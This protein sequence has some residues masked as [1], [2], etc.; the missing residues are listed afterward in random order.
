MFDNQK[1]DGTIYSG[2]DKLG[3]L[4]ISTIATAPTGNPG[5]VATILMTLDTHEIWYY[6]GFIASI[7]TWK[8]LLTEADLPD[9]LTVTYEDA[10]IGDSGSA[11]IVDGTLNIVF[12]SPSVTPIPASE[13]FP[14]YPRA[15]YPPNEGE[16][17][18]WFL[19]CPADGTIQI[20]CFVGGMNIYIT[21]CQGQWTDEEFWPMFNSSGECATEPPPIF[22][23]MYCADGSSYDPVTCESAGGS[24]RDCTFIE[25]ESYMALQLSSYNE[26]ATAWVWFG[27]AYNASIENIGSVFT[28]AFFFANATKLIGNI[29]EVIFKCTVANGFNPFETLIECGESDFATGLN[30]WHLKGAGE[31]P[32]VPSG[33]DCVAAGSWGGDK[34]VPTEKTIIIIGYIGSM[35]AIPTVTIDYTVTA[36]GQQLY[37]VFWRHYPTGWNGG[38]YQYIDSS[39]GNHTHTNSSDFGTY[40]AVVVQI[41]PAGP[42][43]SPP[44]YYLNKVTLNCS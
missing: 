21:E 19:K 33:E 38:G 32:C 42:E 34:F 44:A 9:E 11:T 18:T 23:L 3:K 14:Y 28:R 15:E 13:K 35:T 4:F 39:L 16:F 17:K 22:P 40:D 25:G 43:Y 41:G 7:H 24:P 29:G 8:R 2:F 5:N 37:V 20:P 36:D 10:P 12:P 1:S 31:E 27:P 6:A 26:T 30:G